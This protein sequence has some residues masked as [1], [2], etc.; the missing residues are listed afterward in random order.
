MRA[1]TRMYHRRDIS[2]AMTGRMLTMLVIGILLMVLMWWKAWDVEGERAAK[3]QEG[4]KAATADAGPS[5]P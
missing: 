4:N 5:L 3:L 2:A 1:F